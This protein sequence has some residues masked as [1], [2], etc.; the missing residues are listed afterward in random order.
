[1]LHPI[2]NCA[3]IGRKIRFFKKYFLSSITVERLRGFFKLFSYLLIRCCGRIIIIFNN[4]IKFNDNWQYETVL[5]EQNGNWCYCKQNR[6][7]LRFVFC[8]TCTHIYYN[9]TTMEVDT[10]SWKSNMTQIHAH[11]SRKVRTSRESL[12]SFEN[13]MF[14][15]LGSTWRFRM[16]FLFYGHLIYETY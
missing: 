8:Y 1:M 3:A 11:T 10:K 6:G 15:C 9:A 4:N 7:D 13:C 5:V 2:L 16:F 12:G 14:R